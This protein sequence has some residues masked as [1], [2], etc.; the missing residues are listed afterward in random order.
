MSLQSRQL[1]LARGGRLL[2]DHVDIDVAPGEALHVA[3]RNGSGKTSLL[4]VLCG[5]TPPLRGSLLWQGRPH[6]ERRD[7]L[8][9]ALVYIGH[10]VGLKDDLTIGENLRTA[11]ALSGHAC[12]HE[13]ARR[14][15]A[16]IGLADR[17]DA[18]V[19][20]LSQGQ[21]RRAALARLA[22][23][24]PALPTAPRL[25]VLDEPFTA[26]DQE[27]TT[28]LARL[29]SSHLASGAILVYTT[30]Q[31]APV[32]GAPTHELRLDLHQARHRR[33]V[34]HEAETC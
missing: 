24:P 13:D 5:L 19:R 30:H 1:A 16:R 4:R 26:L 32:L 25:L 20:T 6:G 15:L 34:H 27:S 10:G 17:V 23:V 8:R 11:S 7:A 2:F 12:S 33:A 9:Q 14:A 18:P 3:G 28:L 31:A 29:L 21:R 22:L